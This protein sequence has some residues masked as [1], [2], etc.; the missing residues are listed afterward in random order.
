[1][2]V[3]TRS[4][5]TRDPQA[6]LERWPASHLIDCP[7]VGD[8]EAEAVEVEHYREVIRTGVPQDVTRDM[9]PGQ[10]VMVAHCCL[11]GGMAYH[12]L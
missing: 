5:A 12:K 10:P 11:C 6:D 4:N 3:A 8:P 7:A 1:M 2:P 9:R